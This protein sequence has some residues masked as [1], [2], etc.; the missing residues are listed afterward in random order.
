MTPLFLIEMMPTIDEPYTGRCDGVV[1]DS[2]GVI[3][4][5]FDEQAD[6]VLHQYIRV[7]DDECPP[8]HLEAY[9]AAC[10]QRAI[11]EAA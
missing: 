8:E 10:A 1:L 7:R 2:N 6:R 5:F 3:W 11:L 4:H 9:Q